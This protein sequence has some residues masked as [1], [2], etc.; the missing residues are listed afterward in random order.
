[1]YLISYA[2]CCFG[3]HYMA[4]PLSSAILKEELVKSPLLDGRNF[5]VIC[6]APICGVLASCAF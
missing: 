1:M 2:L 6:D 4:K 5:P 3:L